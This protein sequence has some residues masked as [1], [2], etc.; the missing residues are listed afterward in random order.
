MI[1]RQYVDLNKIYP[2]HRIESEN[3]AI[4]RVSLTEDQVKWEK[5]RNFRDY[6]Y[7]AGL[8][9]NFEYVNLIQKG[10]GV[11]MS[12]TPMERNTNRH[13]IENAN[14][15][16]IVF[17]LG[18]GMIIIPLLS[19]ENIKSI[20]VVELYQ[21]LIDTVVPFLKPFDTQNKL[22]VVQGDCFDYTPEK[23]A[24]YD[25]IYFDIWR[26]ICDDNYEEQKKLTRKFS[27]Y[28]NRDN[29]KAF[30]DAWLKS[31][32]QKERAKEKRSGGWW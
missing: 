17:G 16:V 6:W 4:N 32:Y 8:Q 11:M 30:S 13:F 29:P 27:K 23:G 14:G 24:K 15:D 28:V 12:D 10:K 18:L 25:T 3:Y 26:D 21:D 22:K 19:D 7:V 5:I 9:A 1:Q 31:H 20:T 2:K